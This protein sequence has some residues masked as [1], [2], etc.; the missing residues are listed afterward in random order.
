[1]KNNKFLK[2]LSTVLVA[3]LIISI[4]PMNDSV[5][6]EM[7][8]S[9][10][11]IVKFIG[12]AVEDI[13]FT[14]PEIDFK[15]EAG[16]YD[17]FQCEV[18]YDKS[19]KTLTVSGS[20]IMPSYD[21]S[22]APWDKYDYA[23]NV[24]IEGE[25]YHIS[26]KAFDN[27]TNLKK[28][29]I[30]GSIV[31]ICESAFENCYALKE[32]TFPE[33]LETIQSR[34]FKNCKKLKRISLPKGTKNINNGAFE[35]CPIEEIVLPSVWHNV[36]SDGLHSS[37]HIGCFFGEKE[38]EDTY[39]VEN[40]AES[41]DVYT[42]YIPYSL[43]KVTVTNDLKSQA[44]ENCIGIEEVVIEK[45]VNKIGESAFRNCTGLK[46]LK[47][48]SI[49]LI[50]KYAFS[51]CNNLFDVEFPDT[52]FGVSYCA[53]EG[54]PWLD[55]RMEEFV[56]VGDGVLLK[57]NGTD[58][59]VI[60]PDTVKSISGAFGGKG[61]IESVEIPDSVKIIAPRSFYGC[62]KIKEINIPQTVEI[63][64]A[65]AI[66]GMCNLESVTI[67]FLGRTINETISSDEN[68]FEHIFTN[69][70]ICE[71]C[72]NANVKHG[73]RS[74]YQIPDSLQEITISGGKIYRSAMSRFEFTTLNLGADITEIDYAAFRRNYA[75]YINIH[76]DIK[77]ESFGKGAFVDCQR[78]EEITIPGVK[79]LDETFVGCLKLEKV[80]LSEGVEELYA[81]FDGCKNLK[82]IEFPDSL[83]TIGENTF[84]DCTSLK[85]FYVSKGV[86]N[87]H[88]NAFSDEAHISKTIE[89]FVV[90]EESKHFYDYNGCVF[91][92]DDLL[93]LYPENKKDNTLYLNEKAKGIRPGALKNAEYI[94][95]ISV[96]E[97]NN[98]LAVLDG[99]LYNKDFTQLIYCPYKKSGDVATPVTL[100]QVLSY[101]FSNCKLVEKLD[102][103]GSDV[104]FEENCLF[105]CEPTEIKAQCL[106]NAFK[107]YFGYNSSNKVNRCKSL[108][109]L[110]LTNQYADIP[111]DFAA[112]FYLEEVDV[113]GDLKI[114]GDDAFMYCDFT[115]F[116][117]PDSVVKVGDSS[118]FAVPLKSIKLSENLEY[119]DKWAFKLCT[120]ESIDLPKTLTYIGDFAFSGSHL[121]EIILTENIKHIGCAVFSGDYLEKAV[122]N[123]G[124][125]SISDELFR[126]CNRLQ[127]VV[128]GTSTQD[129]GEASFADCR[130]LETVVIPD[131]VKSISDNA[132]DNSSDNLTIYC[133][134]GSYAEE[135]AQE[136][137]IQYT[138]LVLDSVENQIYTGEEIKPYVGAS[139]NGKRL[140]L[141]TEY[142]VD[143][144][145]NINAGSAKIIASGLGDF[146]ALI[147]VG[148][149]TIL[150]KEM[151]SIEIIS[152]DTE[153][154]PLA[155]DFKVDVYVDGIQ[156]I[157]NVD[158][159]L[160][161]ET[162]ICD[163]GENN[164]AVCGIGNYSGITNITVN[165]LPRD[166]SEA[167]IEI[168]E[169]VT[170]TDKGKKLIKDIDY[171]ETISTA[172]NGKEIIEI[173][174]IGNYDGAVFCSEEE[175]FSFS[176]IEMLIDFIRGLI[177][178]L[179][180]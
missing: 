127:T 83:K 43:K 86:E 111:E 147:A 14:L 164:I 162:K 10:N 58:K 36:N 82:V 104:T 88:L 4:A 175:Q 34:A 22:D 94:E 54:N 56:L 130:A 85:E 159:E 70:Y 38:Y 136:N 13:D 122:I 98:A 118:F 89:S 150:P 180:M 172:E 16:L 115:E 53:F 15:A 59:N 109:K 110:T 121:R 178:M 170:V 71:V 76:K 92:C 100:L 21:T 114:I 2:I 156:L 61:S 163:V 11:G 79:V 80:V 167:D 66:A 40:K 128:V 73:S 51:N 177:K 137:D 23:E 117:M 41:G 120:F 52:V 166:I 113:D 165:V 105:A 49:G 18:R 145:N 32:I 97:K 124:L 78:L 9:A 77:V 47:F 151:E 119:I 169:K 20:G 152:Q 5:V 87:I 107:Y 84:S 12:E 129:V 102:F 42:F 101:A 81:T 33:S 28:V 144:K 149:F 7:K 60:I 131:S 6:T 116:D 134:E 168:G 68:C 154:D 75:K 55:N 174:G 65:E 146:K 19:L 24:I 125:V 44:F 45:N 3:I 95:T 74:G 103:S 62:T 64:E 139:A 123:D 99:V 158:Y 142:T 138:T 90:S 133:N 141:D 1:M 39:A 35:N 143:Y 179:M 48:K 57:Y 50:E 140:S 37:Y 63:L 173:R 26:K 135:Y 25:I 46:K 8:N 126:H 160:V 96:D 155:I 148:K 176:F 153:F 161:T 171:I 106:K 17:S 27:F 30:T 91:T 132:F 31:I 69:G 93:Y 72:N 112:G 157:K 67:P 29:I 108:V